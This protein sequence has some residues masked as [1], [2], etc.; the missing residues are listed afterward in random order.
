LAVLMS[1][2]S[3]GKEL[4]LFW[5]KSSISAGLFPKELYTYTSVG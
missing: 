5:K 1:H 3:F 2:M 4:Y